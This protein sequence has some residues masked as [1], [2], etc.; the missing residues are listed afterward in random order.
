[1][2]SITQN[3]MF[4]HLSK[5]TIQ[6]ICVIMLLLVQFDVCT[7]LMDAISY[8]MEM[9]ENPMAEEEASDEVYYRTGKTQQ[10][11][12]NCLVM[13]LL[14]IIKD[15]SILTT[16]IGGND[17]IPKMPGKAIQQHIVYCVYRI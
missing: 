9:V 14:S 13:D 17:P 7:P 1:M 12:S 16:F 2:Q 8:Q 11:K 4:F 10:I 15:T 6:L 5:H 3:F